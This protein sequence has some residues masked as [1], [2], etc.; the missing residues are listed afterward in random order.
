MP[1]AGLLLSIALMPMLVPAFWHQ[2]FGKVT[3]A[4]TLAFFVPF[5]AQFGPALAA[6]SLVHALLAEFI[7]FTVLLGALYTVAGGIFMRG[8]LRGSPA[9]NV[10]LLLTGT[11]LASVMGTTGASMLLI[12]PLIRANDNRQHRAH[13]VVFFIFLVSNAGGALTPLGDPPLFLGFLKGVDFFWTARHLF[14]HTLFMVASLLLV[15]YL[16]DRWFYAREGVLP[17]APT[18]TDQRLGFDGARNFWLLGGVLALVLLSGVWKSPVSFSVMG[19]Q[20]GL[21]G[22]VRDAG[23]LAIMALSLRITPRA[24]YASNQFSW[25]PMQEVAKLFAGIFLTIIPLIA[26]LKVGIGGPFGAVV[27][28]VTGPDGQPN[29]AMYFWATGLLSSFLDNAPTYLVFFNI[30]GGDPATLMTSLAPTLAAISAGAVFM[31]ANTYI[32]NAPNLMVKSIA[33]NRGVPMPGFFGY[34][35]WSGV[36]L[37]PLFGLISLVGF[38]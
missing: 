15:F 35:A 32:G 21:P 36:V 3:A 37:M 2:H 13:V 25:A 14:A 19:T 5:A 4:W 30:A 28:A 12:R 29:P 6:E 20:V 10:G 38:S 11:L 8:N 27:G 1:F 17:L 24:V 16:L 34:M 9:L 22:A 26:L 23:L 33:E 31:G 7:P 18:P